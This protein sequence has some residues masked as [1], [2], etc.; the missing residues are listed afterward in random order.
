[1]KPLIFA[2]S[3]ILALSASSSFAQCKDYEPNAHHRELHRKH[4][5]SVSY[6]YPIIYCEYRDDDRGQLYTVC[7]ER[8]SKKCVTD[9]YYSNDRSHDC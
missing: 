9:Y 7:H 2:F 1:M 3:A 5:E 6:A 4:Y 8:D